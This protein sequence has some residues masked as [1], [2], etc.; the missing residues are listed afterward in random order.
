MINTENLDYFPFPNDFL[1]DKV[2]F[3]GAGSYGKVFRSVSK[4]TGQPVAIKQM[5]MSK[6]R[7]ENLE[8]ALKIEIQTMRDLKSENTV[9]MIDAHI[10][11]VY[12]YIILELCDTDLRKK[13]V[14]SPIRFS[15]N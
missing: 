7:E 13:M 15:E 3:L 10:G 14:S 4:K 5:N 8:E 2:E 6:I 11:P 9:E 1:I 12:T